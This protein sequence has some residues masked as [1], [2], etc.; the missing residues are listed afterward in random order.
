MAENTNLAGT[1]T[2]GGNTT[3]ADSADNTEFTAITTQEQLNKILGDRLARERAK[4]ADYSELQEKAAK[5]DAAEEAAKTELEKAL[6]RAEKAETLVKEYETRQQVEE[7]KQQVAKETGV[8]VE[9]LR[10]S[11][12]EDLQ[13]HGEQLKTMIGTQ[14]QQQASNT[15]YLPREGEPER[16]AH[17]LNGGG[18]LAALNKLVK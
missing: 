7:W 9:A 3:D 18:L 8:P 14:Q 17:A 1:N 2:A 5:F 13:V 6:S 4:Y 15:V 11:T 16:D 12:L 10:G